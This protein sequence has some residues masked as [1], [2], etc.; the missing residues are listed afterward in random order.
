MLQLESRGLV[1]LTE[2]DWIREARRKRR[3]GFASQTARHSAHGDLP[4][5]LAVA[6][7]IA[8]T[9][10]SYHAFLGEVEALRMKLRFIVRMKR[11]LAEKS[12][13]RRG[14]RYSM[15]RFGFPI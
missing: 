10:L 11:K 8:S 5:A 14:Q 6:S 7:C 15:V 12:R 4:R 2:G 9:D 3:G 1:P 13:L